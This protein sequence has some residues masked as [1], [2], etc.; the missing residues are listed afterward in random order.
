MHDTDNLDFDLDD[1]ETDMAARK[2]QAGFK[3]FKAKKQ[4]RGAD[5]ETGAFIG[6]MS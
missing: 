2:I 3:H 1:P 6:V 5:T 4:Q